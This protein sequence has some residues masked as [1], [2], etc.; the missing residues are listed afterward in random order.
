MRQFVIILGK[1][2]IINYVTNDKYMY[3]GIIYWF[4]Y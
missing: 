2:N 1:L 3:K 4:S